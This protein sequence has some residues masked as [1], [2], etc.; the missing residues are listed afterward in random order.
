MYNWASYRA[1]ETRLDRAISDLTRGRLR[2]EEPSI[3]CDD[4]PRLRKA[5]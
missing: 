4:S 2:E 3:A 5:A 1:V